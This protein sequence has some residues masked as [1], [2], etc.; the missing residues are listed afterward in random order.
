MSYIYFLFLLIMIPNLNGKT[1]YPGFN[2]FTSS[3]DLSLGGSGFLIGS[4]ISTKLNPGI[5]HENK[6]ISTSLIRYPA[7]ITSENIGIGIPL[8]EGSAALSIFHITYGVFQGYNELA[9]KT[10][11]Y[12]S[13]DLSI[14]VSYSKSFKKLPVQYGLGT[15]LFRSSL[16]GINNYFVDIS[17]GSI[18]KL[19]KNNTKLGC[20]IH[21]IGNH[22]YNDSGIESSIQLVFSIS[23]NLNYLPVEVFIDYI[24]K[25]KRKNDEFFIG[26]R[27]SAN[28]KL[29][30]NFGTS[31]R[32]LT[33]NLE[34]S[35]SQSILGDTGF[36]F[37]YTINTVVINYGSF[38]YNNGFLIHSL[39][40]EIPI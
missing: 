24:K 28:K 15:Q 8:K 19:D 16:N 14:R 17:F 9:E 23:K 27:L 36:G 5:K 37:S 32:K 4:S 33:Q 18:L 11:K 7:Q 12:I 39:G 25:G 13:Q 2:I 10:S 34:Q 26:G 21:H 6:I 1:A 29:K 35:L 20:S 40:I 3:V 31:T 38:I 30:I 22:I